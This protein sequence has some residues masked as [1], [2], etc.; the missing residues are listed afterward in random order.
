MAR[1]GEDCSAPTV[2]ADIEANGHLIAAA[3]E[4]LEALKAIAGATERFF[5]EKS[6]SD[7]QLFGGNYVCPLEQARKAIAKAE[8]QTAA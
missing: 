2:H 4:L 1:Y 8:G 5:D 6:L 3:P 7:D